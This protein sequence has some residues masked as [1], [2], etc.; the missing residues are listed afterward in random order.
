VSRDHSEQ[1]MIDA[2]E[3]AATIASDRSR[4]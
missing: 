2:F 1:R 4:W 3:A